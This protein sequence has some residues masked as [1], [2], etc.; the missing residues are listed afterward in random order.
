MTRVWFLGGFVIGAAATA[1]IGVLMARELRVGL[2][3]IPYIV[4]ESV[5]VGMISGGF[6][7]AVYRILRWLGNRA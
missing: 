6:A 5:F 3:V 4:L 1:A 7:A 2:D